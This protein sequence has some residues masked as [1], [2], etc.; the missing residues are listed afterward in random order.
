MTDAAGNTL[1]L[2]RV[3]GQGGLLD[4]AVVEGGLPDGP[5]G[6]DFKYDE[7][8]ILLGPGERDDVVVAIPA[9]SPTGRN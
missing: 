9:R 5:G 1:P 2:V 8:E 4:N 7:G 6:F 3:G